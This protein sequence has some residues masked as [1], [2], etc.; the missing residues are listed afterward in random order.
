VLPLLAAP[1]AVRAQQAGYGQTLGGPLEDNGAD[2]GTGAPRSTGNAFDATNPIDLMNRLRRATAL[3]EATPP[4]DAV[5]A[6]LRDFEAQPASPG[7][8]QMQAP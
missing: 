4:G 1:S 5:D 6:A 7:S 3:D 8:S 2:V